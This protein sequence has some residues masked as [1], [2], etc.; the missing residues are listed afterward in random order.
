MQGEVKHPDR[1]ICEDFI[2]LTL[3]DLCYCC[4]CLFLPNLQQNNNIMLY[5]NNSDKAQTLHIIYVGENKEF[6]SPW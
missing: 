5:K 2:M 1:S 6:H 4:C 3:P